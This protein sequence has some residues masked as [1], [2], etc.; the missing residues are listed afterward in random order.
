MIQTGISYIQQ[1]ILRIFDAESLISHGGLLIAFL[2]VYGATGLFFCFF[3]PVGAV[4]FAAGVLIAT[5]GLHYTIFTVC[6]LLIFAS[7]LG[8]ISDY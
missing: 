8:H 6:S 3:L 1:S 4:L 7:V 2:V 5:G